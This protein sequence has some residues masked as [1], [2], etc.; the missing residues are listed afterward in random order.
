M[1]KTKLRSRRRTALRRILIAA[2]A[3]LIVTCVLG[4]GVFFPT[5]IIR[6]NEER[7]GTGRTSIVAWDWEPEIH[8][9]QMLYLTGNEHVT[10][11]IGSYRTFLGW[12]SNFTSAV[13][14][15]K[16]EPLY[17]S[18]ISVSTFGRNPKDFFYYY[19][20]VDDP[21]IRCV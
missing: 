1:K 16:E 5:Q 19:G 8:Q 15:S 12:M 13:D 17:A 18:Q 10:F 2:A 14:C 20:R 7:H 6:Q 9:T 11:L 3:Y 4:T 21:E